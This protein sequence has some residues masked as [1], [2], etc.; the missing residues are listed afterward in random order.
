MIKFEGKKAELITP[1]PK[2]S[3]TITYNKRTNITILG[4]SNKLGFWQE[5]NYLVVEIK[6]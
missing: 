2:D 1:H 4:I 3:Y 6:K 5:T